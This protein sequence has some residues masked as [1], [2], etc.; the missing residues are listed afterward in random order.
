MSTDSFVDFADFAA[1]G[2]GPQRWPQ[3]ARP[4]QVPACAADTYGR[5]WK[6]QMWG[7]PHG[8]CGERDSDNSQIVARRGGVF[9]GAARWPPTWHARPFSRIKH[10]IPAG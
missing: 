3:A 4:R 5:A 7:I 6:W 8:E 9:F 1:Q 2:A 10:R